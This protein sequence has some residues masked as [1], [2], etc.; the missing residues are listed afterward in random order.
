M[1]FGINGGSW[2]QPPS[3]TEKQLK[4]WGSQKLYVDFWL[5]QHS[6]STAYPLRN[7]LKCWPLEPAIGQ[8]L[9]SG[10]QGVAKSHYPGSQALTLRKLESLPDSGP[11]NALT[12]ELKLLVSNS[13]GKMVTRVCCSRLIFWCYR[14][15]GSCLKKKNSLSPLL[16]TQR[17]RERVEFSFLR[18]WEKSYYI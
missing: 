10:H 13:V 14:V 6:E 4:F 15:E 12:E 5:H 3:N 11:H 18:R 7:F 1:D 16:H 8:H 9:S 2:K 17:S